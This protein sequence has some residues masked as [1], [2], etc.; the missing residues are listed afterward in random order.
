MVRREDVADDL[1]Q[2]VFYRAWAARGRYK[3]QGT[4]LAYLLK[5]A[6]HLVC[7][8][9]RRHQA[10]RNLDEE[11]WKR[12]AP[13]SPAPEPPETAACAEQIRQLLAVLDRLSPIQRR[14]LLLRY[15]GQ[16]SFAEIA[17]AI[18]CPLNT[19]L[20]HC[21]RALETLRKLLGGNAAGES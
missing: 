10:E 16:L 13:L 5:I 3:E 14:V 11:G 17:E 2:E 4:S 15:Y 6:D 18:A 20:S 21:H 8:R 7:D 19:T 1:K 12:H 9:Y